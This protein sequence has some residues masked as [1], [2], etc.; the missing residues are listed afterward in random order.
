MNLT[1]R[2]VE[3]LRAELCRAVDDG[4]PHAHHAQI[5]L[6]DGPIRLR[7]KS[8]ILA[9]AEQRGPG[10]STCPSDA[11]RAIGG[12]NWRELMDEARGIARELAKSGSVQITQ[13][14]NVVDPDTAW[15]G[16]IRIRSAGR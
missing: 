9:L 11:A 1:G 6:G 7:L 3:R 13:R 16:P 2:V 12:E 15:R 10:S 8:A 5:A 4:G 14:G